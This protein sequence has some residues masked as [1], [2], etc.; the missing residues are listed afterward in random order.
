M[1]PDCPQTPWLGWFGTV[2][3]KV[4]EALMERPE[5]LEPNA[6][7]EARKDRP[8]ISSMSFELGFLDE[9]PGEWRNLDSTVRGHGDGPGIRPG[10]GRAGE[11]VADRAD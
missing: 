10:L 8:V 6:I 11:A 7:A 2:P 1:P 4:H 3:A 9:A 5:D